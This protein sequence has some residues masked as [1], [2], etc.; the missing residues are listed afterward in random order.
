VP[1]GPPHTRQ[2][3]LGQSVASRAEVDTMLEKA[4]AA[5]A[6]VTPPTSD[7]G[8]STPATSAT[9]TDTSGRSSGTRVAHQTQADTGTG[10]ADPHPGG[11]ANE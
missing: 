4:A 3:G 2:F 11:A 8:A 7:P 6:V 9:R 1:V 5:G 10:Q